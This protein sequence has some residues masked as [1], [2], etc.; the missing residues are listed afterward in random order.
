MIDICSGTYIP[1]RRNGGDIK[2]PSN[3]CL[4]TEENERICIIV[5]EFI[6]LRGLNTYFSV[7]IFHQAS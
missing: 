4:N 7:H 2:N 3:P 6:K 5:N 1:V